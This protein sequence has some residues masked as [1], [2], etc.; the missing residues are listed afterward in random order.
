MIDCRLGRY[1]MKWNWIELLDNDKLLV[2]QNDSLP[3]LNE[4]GL[5]RYKLK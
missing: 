4:C 1:I 5:G 3:V 2:K